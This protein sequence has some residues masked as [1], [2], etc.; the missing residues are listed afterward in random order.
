M[1]VE[2]GKTY[3]A[4]DRKAWRAWL[5]THHKSAQEIWLIYYKKGS[6]RPRIA[7]SDAV[8]EA[9][10]F[11]WIDSIVKAIDEKKYV[12]RFTP[13]NPR[14]QWSEM[15]RERMRRL[16][17]AGLM[18][19][20]G[21]AVFDRKHSNLKS[22]TSNS[23]RMRVVV[24]ADIKAALM[25][26]KQTWNNFQA[27]PESYK[28]IRVWWIDAVRKRPAAFRQRLRYFLKMTAQNKRFGMVQ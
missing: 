17:E 10:C 26:E 15:N 19:P 23:T 2:I 9:L 4:P 14:S 28:C 21:L 6:R 8:E 16:I 27:F 1:A 12:Q 5:K 24:P 22:R 18:T 3:Y 7:Y 11:G 13:R 20:A 25:K